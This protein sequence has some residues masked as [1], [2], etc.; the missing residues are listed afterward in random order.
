MNPEDKTK[1][2]SDLVHSGVIPRIVRD[3]ASG[4]CFEC[5]RNVS[6]SVVSWGDHVFC[7]CCF[8]CFGFV[9]LMSIADQ[10]HF[11]VWRGLFDHDYSNICNGCK[12]CGVENG[13][14]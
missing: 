1:V 12:E 3:V 9:P 5:N 2:I 11:C 8:D 13:I 6:G 14:A 4:V 10:K 7:P